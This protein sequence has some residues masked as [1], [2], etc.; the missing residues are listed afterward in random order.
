MNIPFRYIQRKTLIHS[1]HPLTKLV[2]V[3]L[4]L[5]LIMMPLY[6]IRDMPILLTW[7]GLSALLWV[8]ARIELSRFT[9]LLKILLGTFI[10]LMLA[11]GL[12]YRYG[13]TVLIKFADFEF[14]QSNLGELTLEGV[15]LGFMLSVRILAAASSLPLLVMT[16][17][18]SELMAA[19]T[20]LRLPKVATFMFV[21]ALSFTT[22]IFEMWMNII[23]A[24]KLR[25]FDV[26]RMN[27]FVRL[28]KA[29]VPIVT[30]LI[31]LLFRKANDF[32]I[33]METKG[34]GSPVRPT[35]V[36]LLY[37]KLPDYL[38]ILIFVSTFLF[39]NWL[40]SVL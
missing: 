23:D 6:D 30:P 13:E 15:Q 12:T 17:S 37:F 22:L 10:F 27:V 40:R 31:L 28:R 24:Q 11:Q 26:D 25:A 35:E 4:T 2:Y 18:N 29:Y 34:F 16:T 21:S 19:L 9:T 8:V 5:L 33:A 32:Q 1:L 20:R 7:L 14:G 39:C 36:E 38:A 3:L